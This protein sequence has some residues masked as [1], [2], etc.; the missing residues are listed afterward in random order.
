MRVYEKLKVLC[1]CYEPGKACVVVW[2]SSVWNA[3]LDKRIRCPRK[4]RQKSQHKHTQT[5]TFN[6]KRHDRIAWQIKFDFFWFI[7]SLLFYPVFDSWTKYKGLSYFSLIYVLVIYS[8]WVLFILA[9][10]DVLSFVFNS[11]LL[12]NFVKYSYVYTHKLSKNI[13]KKL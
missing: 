9:H 1:Q 5:E 10:T 8:V 4:F 12:E 6:R 11:N 2:T 3:I 7:W 13:P